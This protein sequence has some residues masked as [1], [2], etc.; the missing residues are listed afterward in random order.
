MTI[1][2][3]SN[4]NPAQVLQPP[5]PATPDPPRSTLDTLASKVGLSQTELL[6]TLTSGSTVDTYA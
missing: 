4:P 1:T 6:S 2:P 3:I 5:R